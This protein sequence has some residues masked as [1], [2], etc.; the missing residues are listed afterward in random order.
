MQ[1]A[2]ADF[3]A[4]F[5]AGFDDNGRRAIFIVAR[6]HQ[7]LALHIFP[8]AGGIQLRRTALVQ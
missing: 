1:P 2:S 7:F 5:V 4:I 8:M 3:D 6:G